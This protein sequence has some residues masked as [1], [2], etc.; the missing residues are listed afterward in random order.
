MTAHAMKGDRERC[1]QAGMDGYVSK[2][3][4]AEAL[5]AAVERRAPPPETLTLDEDALRQHFGGDEAFFREVAGVFLECSPAWLADI[6][7]AIES[8]D[9][10]KLRIA[11][12][13][14]KGAVSHFGASEVQ[15]AADQLE[16]L[17]K[18]GELQSSRTILSALDRSLL[19]LQ[20]ALNS[21]TASN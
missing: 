11:A 18:R 1:L 2:P 5:Y 14:L 8:G 6:R 17:A 4:A 7:A 13:T 3:L 19:Q 12:H 20:A 21:R 16:Q 9:T 15:A 10:S